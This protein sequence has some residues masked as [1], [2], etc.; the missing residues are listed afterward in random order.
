LECRRDSTLGLDGLD[1]TAAAG[2]GNN[3]Q[4]KKKQNKR[5]HGALGGEL[6][7]EG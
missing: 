2:G 1:W 7:A 6:S 3:A 5:E 4:R